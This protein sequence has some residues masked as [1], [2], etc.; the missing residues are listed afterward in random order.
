MSRVE[1]E[2]VATRADFVAFVRAVSSADANEWENPQ[3]AGYLES[4]AAWVEDWPE[5]LAP[6]WSNF[7]KAILAATIYE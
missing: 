5:E 1:P 7:A 3:T 6:A 4:L 2:A